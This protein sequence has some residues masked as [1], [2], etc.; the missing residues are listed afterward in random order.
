MTIGAISNEAFLPLEMLFSNVK[1]TS[2]AQ[3]ITKNDQLIQWLKDNAKEIK[4]SIL[5]GDSWFTHSHVVEHVV[6]VAVIWYGMKFI[7]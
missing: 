6:E 3:Q 2:A 1:G 4:G 5:L 7:D